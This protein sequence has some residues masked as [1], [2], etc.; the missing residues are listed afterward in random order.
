MRIKWHTG[1][2]YGGMSRES[3]SNR[4]QILFEMGSRIYQT[5]RTLT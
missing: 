1:V 3:A 5:K 4:L 2:G